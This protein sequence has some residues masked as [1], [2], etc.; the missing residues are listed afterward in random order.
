MA[1]GYYKNFA[2][3]QRLDKIGELL[4]KGV[5]L[6]HQK[7]ADETKN[8]SEEKEALPILKT[9]CRENVNLAPAIYLAE[10]IFT[11]KETMEFLKISRTTLWRLRKRREIP[12]CVISNRR[13]IR[14]KLSEIL[15]YLEINSK[16]S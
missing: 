2:P 9:K 3:E 1:I 16:P 10:K 5:Y 13:L 8:S 15:N 11:T 12:Y 4:A 6:Y 14:F 7:N